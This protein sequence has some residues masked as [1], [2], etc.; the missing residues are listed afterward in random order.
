MNTLIIPNTVN[1]NVIAPN[2][3]GLLSVDEKIHSYRIKSKMDTTS[4]ESE[5]YICEKDNKEYVLKYYLY[6]KPKI[7]ICEILKTINNPHII[8]LYDY[9]EYKKHFF[10]VIEYA[11]GGALN[12]RNENKKFAYLPIEENKAL[13][14]VKD[15][16]K[17]LNEL[18]KAGIVHRDIKPGNIFYRNT[19]K[20]DVIIGDF[21][22]STYIDIDD[23][24]SK[25]ITETN[26]RTEG[27][28]APEG[29][30]SIIGP[31]IDYYALGVTVWEIITGEEPFLDS[32]GKALLPEKIIYDTISGTVVDNLLARSPNLSTKI[33]TLIQGLMTR[34]HD[35]RWNY[36]SVIEFLNGEDVPVY[37]E[38]NQL[39]SIR[40]NDKECT[41]F[42]EIA[43]EL[44]NDNETG[45]QFVYKG[46][47]TKYLV[48]IDQDLA[49]EIADKIDEYSA[50]NNLDEG[51]LYIAYKLCPTLGF[52]LSDETTVCS[53]MDIEKI[54]RENPNIILPF[55]SD[56]SKGFYTYLKII[57]LVELS[58]KLWE[59]KETSSSVELIIPRIL[60]A[61]KN[62]KIS[63][64]KDGINDEICLSDSKDFENLPENLKTRLMYFVEAGNKNI[65]SW[66]E[67]ATGKQIFN[68]RKETL[69]INFEKNNLSKIDFF[70]YFLLG[71]YKLNNLLPDTPE[72]IFNLLDSIKNYSYLTNIIIDCTY[73]KYYNHADY[74]NCSKL[75]DRLSENSGG[76]SKEIDYYWAKNAECCLFLNKSKKALNLCT[77]AQNKNKKS[78]WYYILGT[79]AALQANYYKQALEMSEKAISINPN[80]SYAF[81]AKGSVLLQIKKYKEAISTFTMAIDI[82]DFYEYYEIRAEA[83]D[84]LADEGAPEFR[85]KASEDKRKATDNLVSY[86]KIADKN[87]LVGIKGRVFD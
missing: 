62:N 53:I 35:K 27:Y 61:F 71:N 73:E 34:R 18:H 40:I 41:S 70:C 67:N 47:L 51:L 20:T 17:A 10:T 32:N 63:P 16:A 8:S 75:L 39:P 11:A 68:W 12:K 64:F 38:P 24:M 59:I 52:K 42:K 6:N 48:K 28:F 60:L 79:D 21:D 55:L 66:F 19:N 15:M 72:K 5:L 1:K 44:L 81:Y 43:E 3:T 69:K 14:L 80:N 13:Q 78:E 50:Q 86:K 9:G 82:D 49:S 74:E 33:K 56:I 29:Y 4:N 31:E 2:A 83:Y 65:C 46:S 85:E 54:L 37:S 25:H 36:E 30:S 76:L 22:I 57:G 58:E 77:D 87:L 7:E 26:T 84:K 45:K 23:G